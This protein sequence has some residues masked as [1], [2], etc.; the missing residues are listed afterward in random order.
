MPFD[1][2]QYQA[3]TSEMSTDQ[4]QKEWENYTR[5]IAGGATST[6]T[7]V[8]FSPL[9][10][11]I[12]LMGL[13]L[14]A[15]R[16]H[17]ARKKR[18]IIERG[19]QERG[20]SHNTRTRDV[21]GSMAL[22][23]AISVATLG[24]AGP[25][26][27]AV[28]GEAVGKGAEY[29]VAHLALDGV[30]EAIEHKH[31]G[32]LK[33]KAD[34]DLKMKAMQAQLANMALQNGAQQQMAMQSNQMA[35]GQ[36]VNVNGQMVWQQMPVMGG[37]QQPALTTG[38][39]L[40][41]AGSM[42]QNSQQI[43]WQ[44]PN[45]DMQLPSM[46]QSQVKNPSM[47]PD[48][49]NEYAVTQQVQITQ[50]QYVG[51]PP[52]YQPTQF[53]RHDSKIQLNVIP[54]IQPQQ[55]V[56]SKY[57]LHVVHDDQQPQMTA[58]G[59]PDEK[60]A[61]YT[62]QFADGTMTP[63]PVYSQQPQEQQNHP[64]HID[65]P[66]A[67]TMEEEIAVLKFKLLQLEMEKRGMSA[68]ISGPLEI[69]LDEPKQKVTEQ[70]AEQQVVA[71]QEVITTTEVIAPQTQ[72]QHEQ[73]AKQPT[74]QVGSHI[75]AQ[76]E[77]QIQSLSSPAQSQ[78]SNALS[79]PPHVATRSPSPQPHYNPSVQAPQ[80]QHIQN[81]TP[82]SQVQYT[83]NVQ[84]YQSQQSLIPVSTPAGRS[85]SP[86]PP[87]QQQ[88]NAPPPQ[89]AHQQYASSQYQPSAPM[90][91]VSRPHSQIP[92]YNPAQQQQTQIY[93]PQ[94]N[95]ATIQAPQT[96][97]QPAQQ[98]TQS[99]YQSAGYCPSPQI[100]RQDSGYYSQASTPFQR[101]V[102]SISSIT[103]PTGR[104]SSISYAPQFSPPPQQQQQYNAAGYNQQRHGRSQS[105]ASISS[106]APPAYF[107]PPPGQQQP[108]LAGKMGGDYFGQVPQ[109]NAYGQQGVQQW[110]QQSQVGGEINYGPPPPIPGRM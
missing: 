23:G 83:A 17:N 82:M 3:K 10:A 91:Q 69:C 58:T 12:S 60:S 28:A 9:T 109:I 71:T 66:P 29:A 102:S 47:T 40:P 63:L 54:N 88:Y 65:M 95:N 57:H 25:L 4:L 35:Q 107:P 44:Q 33:K 100:Q 72:A 98:Y 86:A 67:M 74:V 68:T 6:A 16:I 8:L 61:A 77:S 36:W 51:N 85:A 49:Y 45:P 27:D 26:A 32:H 15:P 110:Q 24:L 89:Q 50:Q 106:P 18:E 31:G 87:A 90:Q 7:S 46:Q 99:N 103:S 94:P 53:V 59:F 42:M 30:G 104:H 5:Q 62:S 22:S 93:Q 2:A 21:T 76:I 101:P 78:H 73:T 80:Y 41:M 1:Y 48:L 55:Q 79:A 38:M 92:A 52:Q 105:I 81:Q 39:V 97:P 96:V 20:S 34:Q 70:I 75:E 43:H 108:V 19:L 11:G 84:A 14:S 64:T 56:D 37:F 13:G